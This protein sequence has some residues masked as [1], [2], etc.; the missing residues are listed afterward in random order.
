MGFS[1]QHRKSCI[2][3]F[4]HQSSSKQ[5]EEGPRLQYWL[6]C[7][8]DAH[9]R[10]FA[11]C[12]YEGACCC[13]SFYGA[14]VSE[15][16]NYSNGFFSCWT[17][18]RR[19]Y[20]SAPFPPAGMTWNESDA[21]PLHLASRQRSLAS[22]WRQ[23][24]PVVVVGGC[25]MWNCYYSCLLEGSGVSEI[26]FWMSNEWCLLVATQWEGLLTLA[27]LFAPLQM[28]AANYLKEEADYC[29]RQEL[30][31]SLLVVV[32]AAVILS[33]S[34]VMTEEYIFI[35]CWPVSAVVCCCCL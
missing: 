6:N 32:I 35:R 25:K 19:S 27:A 31:S 22:A 17:F 28:K 15:G 11:S 2:C 33:A 12:F 5:A 24:V 9:P 13:S 14:V 3:C 4:A 18:C 26:R 16:R 30:S 1:R 10:R 34:S 20:F 7:G 29:N 21:P 8:E 23:L